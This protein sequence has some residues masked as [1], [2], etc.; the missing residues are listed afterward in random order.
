VG[1]AGVP[2]E[3]GVDHD[4]PRVL[5]PGMVGEDGVDGFGRELLCQF[6]RG[7]RVAVA[8]ADAVGEPSANADRCGRV[9]DGSECVAIDR[10]WCGGFGAGARGGEA[11]ESLTDCLGGFGVALNAEFEP[12]VGAQC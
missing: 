4:L 1:L 2:E 6:E 12:A 9:V 3:E 8:V 11:P 5:R 10:W 7:E